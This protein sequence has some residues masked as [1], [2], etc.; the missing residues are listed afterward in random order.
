MIKIDVQNISKKIKL[1]NRISSSRL[2]NKFQK[3]IN[4]LKKK[5]F[6]IRRK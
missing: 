5:E 4:Y 6:K 1:N 2:S 3:T